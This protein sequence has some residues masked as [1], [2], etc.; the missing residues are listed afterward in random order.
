M[1]RSGQFTTSTSFSLD[2]LSVVLCGRRDM[3]PARPIIFPLHRPISH[4]SAVVTF[5]KATAQTPLLFP[6]RPP[7]AHTA[8][9]FKPSS[10]EASAARLAASH[11]EDLRRRPLPPAQP[12]RRRPVPLLRRGRPRL[13]H[14]QRIPRLPH[15]PHRR[16][17]P[18]LV[19]R[20]R[21]ET[22]LPRPYP[23]LS[24]SPR[25]PPLPDPRRPARLVLQ[26]TCSAGR[27][28][29]SGSTRRSSARSSAPPSTGSTGR[30]S[31]TGRPAAARRSP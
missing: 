16:P 28:R 8:P 2:I 19:L 30:P 6:S 17:R 4:A 22:R 1:L 27:R 20:L 12:G 26:T 10:S 9:N 24:S 29:T 3:V 11:G 21:Y 31:P 23:I 25:C 18:R 7:S 5:A 15:P 13:A 14:R